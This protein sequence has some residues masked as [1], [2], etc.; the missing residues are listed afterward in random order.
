MNKTISI[1]GVDYIEQPDTEL[2]AKNVCPL[3][4]FYKTAC[5]NRND[6][7]CHSDALPDGVGVIFVLADNP[8]QTEENHAKN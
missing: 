5:Y 1:D 8:V 4:A 3:C 7:T 6:F 2:T